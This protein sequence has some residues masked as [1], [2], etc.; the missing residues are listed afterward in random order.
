MELALKGQVIEKPEDVLK[1]PYIL[2]F[3]GLE[4]RTE[5]SESE[6]ESR[7]L[8]HLQEFLLEL[9]KGFAFIGRQVRFTFEAQAEQ[10]QA[11]V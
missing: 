1:D 11:A 8:D 10:G 7:L 9:G 5:F 2:E 3:T 4:E 6:L